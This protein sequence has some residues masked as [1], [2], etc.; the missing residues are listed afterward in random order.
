MA[1][2]Y[3]VIPKY[4]DD[5]QKCI[6]QFINFSINQPYQVVN[7]EMVRKFLKKARFKNPETFK[8]AYQQIFVQSKKCYVVTFCY[9]TDHEITEDFRRLKDVLLDYQF[10]Q[11]L[12]GCYYRFSSN[13]VERWEKNRVMN[14]A[15]KVFLKPLLAL[16]SKTL[17]R[18]ILK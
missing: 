7:S 16:F 13:A 3:D 2:V 5:C 14:V 1:R 4:F 15:A 10:G 9:G 8:S 11:E 18:I 12:V 17:L 6:E